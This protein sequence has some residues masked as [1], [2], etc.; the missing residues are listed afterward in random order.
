VVREQKSAIL[1]TYRQ[2]IKG[3]G[4]G[5]TRDFLLP[6]PSGG[7]KK[8]PLFSFEHFKYHRLA[9]YYRRLFGE[10]RVLVLPYEMFVRTPPLFVEEIIHFSGQSSLMICRIGKN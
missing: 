7:G 5:S 6:P 4:C 8:L 1:S 2:Y 10:D 3:G 9:G